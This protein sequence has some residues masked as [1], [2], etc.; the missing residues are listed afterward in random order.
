MKKEVTVV[1]TLSAVPGK[2]NELKKALQELVPHCRKGE[3]CLQYDLFEP[4]QGKGEFLILMRWKEMKNLRSHESSF[5]IKEFVRKYDR[6]LYDG[7]TQTEWH[8]V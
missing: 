4:C 7:F 5:H 1:E 8:A 6:I 2:E 3:G